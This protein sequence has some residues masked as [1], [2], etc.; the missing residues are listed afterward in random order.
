MPLM[1]FRRD[2]IV[3]PV[4]LQ[5]A[6]NTRFTQAL[7]GQSLDQSLKLFLIH[8]QVL[9]TP[10]FGPMKLAPVQASG[11]QPQSQPIMY[12]YLDPVGALVGKRIGTMRPGA[13]EHLNHPGQCLVRTGAHVQ[14]FGGQPDFVN[15]NH[16]SSSRSSAR[17]RSA[18]E[19]GQLTF[20]DC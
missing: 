8:N 18:C 14:W 1:A 3:L 4:V 11:T 12:Q 17:Q 19:A 15:A 7:P 6:D 16:C 9:A 5:S 20:I 13:A 2:L 10:G